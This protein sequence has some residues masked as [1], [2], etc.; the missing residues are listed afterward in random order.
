MSKDKIALVRLKTDDELIAE[1]IPIPPERLRY[2]ELLKKT[3]NDS[4]TEEELQEL[5]SFHSND[6]PSDSP[7][8]QQLNKQL[9]DNLK[10]IAKLEGKTVEQ[11]REET[12]KT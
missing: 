12:L 3:M 8:M 9:E 11:V 2:R 4:I 10:L 5:F 7:R 1:G 6:Q